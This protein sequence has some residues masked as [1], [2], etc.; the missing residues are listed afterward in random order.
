MY[1][2]PLD[3][4][5]ESEPGAVAKRLERLLDA[6]ETEITA[7]VVDGEILTGVNRLKYEML[8]QLR[9][10][11]W[12]VRPLGGLGWHVCAPKEKGHV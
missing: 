9:A 12:A 4:G 1:C 7:N 3:A 2:K 11:G 5:M 10:E 6:L 8:T